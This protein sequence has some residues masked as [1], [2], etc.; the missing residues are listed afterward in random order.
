[1]AA[2]AELDDS[3]ISRQGFRLILQCGIAIMLLFCAAS[4]VTLARQPGLVEA[5]SAAAD[6]AF[7]IVLIAMYVLLGRLR[8]EVEALIL[9]GTIL[10]YSILNILLFPN[11]LIRIVGAP[12]LA[13]V[14]ALAYVSSR[15]LR[16]LSITAWLTIVS[17]FWLSNHALISSEPIVDF[18]GLSAASAII[19]LVLSQF[20]ARMKRALTDAQGANAALQSERGNLEAQVA[21]RTASLQRALD[22]LEARSAEQARLLAETEQQRRAIRALSLPI[23]PLNRTTLAAPLVGDFDA[24]RLA[25]LQQL[26]LEAIQRSG[27]KA[28]VLDIT[29]IP[30]V[31]NE[32]ALGIL[33]IAQAA[34]L[35]GARIVLAGIRPEVAQAIVSLGMDLA[36][37]QTAATLQDG[38]AAAGER[39]TTDGRR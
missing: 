21:E 1:M 35:M 7:T 19:L 10:V 13:I 23:L 38:I 20:H 3:Q 9:A 36:G 2:P 25:E 26:A 5:L 12:L 4:L 32:V 39:A 17:I 15:Q 18:V 37:L 30:A 29:G 6:I 11:A 31:D 22:E 27:A 14:L 16:A 33:R 24:Q 28:L 8:L 34:R